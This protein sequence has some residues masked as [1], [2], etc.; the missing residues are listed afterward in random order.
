MKTPKTYLYVSAFL[1]LIAV[2]LVLYWFGWKA[3]VCGF[4]FEWGRNAYKQYKKQKDE[5][6]D[7]EFGERIMEILK[8][9]NKKASGQ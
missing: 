2:I 6:E 3:L 1:S 7:N 9:G 8:D 5:D 4:I